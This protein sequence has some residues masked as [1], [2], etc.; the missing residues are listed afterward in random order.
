MAGSQDLVADLPLLAAVSYEAGFPIDQFLAA[1]AATLRREN[2]RLGG[3]IQQNTHA[4]G[5]AGHACCAD[6]VLVDL[7]TD[8]RIIISQD[9]GLEAQACRLDASG[10]VEMG[11]RLEIN[12]DGSIDLLILNKF[13]KAEVDGGGFRGVIARAMEFGVPLLTA[14]R[15]LH[16]EAWQS[17]HGGL[18]VDLAPDAE[19]V[20]DW[21]RRAARAGRMARSMRLAERSA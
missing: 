13:G 5:A 11:G 10:L 4:A 8:D 3:A 15:S 1:V 7:A 19:G 21:C 12:V 6:M 14:V 18:A 9:L 20:L 17:F 16:R 2:L